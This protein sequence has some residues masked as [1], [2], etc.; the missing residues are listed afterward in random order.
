MYA[1]VTVPPSEA[2]IT[3]QYNGSQRQQL[4]KRTLVWVNVVP[5]HPPVSLQAASR[6]RILRDLHLLIAF[7]YS[8]LPLGGFF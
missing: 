5:L 3:G 1:G 8:V 4:A 7:W 2:E 6:S